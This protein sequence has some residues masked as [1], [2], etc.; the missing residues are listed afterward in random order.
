MSVDTNTL[1]LA[2]FRCGI[3]IEYMYTF[4]HGI[5]GHVQANALISHILHCF[6]TSTYAAV[7][8]H[9]SEY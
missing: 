3:A 9:L 1:G 5:A 7:H 8:H 2:L 6:A 4:D